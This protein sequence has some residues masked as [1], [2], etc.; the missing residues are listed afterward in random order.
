VLRTPPG[1]GS[2][3]DQTLTIQK[4]DVSGANNGQPWTIRWRLS[5]L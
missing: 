4:I 3:I 2:R 1:G 5:P